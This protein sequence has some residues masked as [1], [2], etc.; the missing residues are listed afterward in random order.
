MELRHLRYFVAVAEEGSLTVAAQKRLFTAQPS[1]SRQMRDLE[2]EVGAQLLER[3]VHGVELTAAGKVFL[4][5]ARLALAQ[6]EAAAT[7]A[8]N[9][10]A[11]GKPGFALGFL[12][13]QEMEWL[14]Q[15]MQALSPELCNLE[16]TVVSQ[17]SPQLA[18]ALSRKK[19]DAAFMRPEPD[20]PDLKYQRV[21][22][23]A[24]MLVLPSDH[25]LARGK[26]VS[27]RELAGE[28]LVHVSETAPVLRGMIDGW[29]KR[30]KLA[31]KVEHAVDNLAMAISLVASTRGVALLPAYAQNFLPW[32]VVGRPLQ[33]A[34]PTI[35]LVIGYR[36]ANE[37]PAL[38]MLLEK[39]APQSE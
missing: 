38:R 36:A 35:D 26:S 19:L 37:S 23:E 33:G 31:L 12:T 9:A 17:Y 20:R 14:P 6:V 24:L 15:A 25:K 10:A 2:E 8:R 1:L 7:A 13:G 18:E 11:P 22:R 29:L 34:A 32:S 16:V 27:P 4:E 30:E 21:A 3:S 28:T 5:H 39:V